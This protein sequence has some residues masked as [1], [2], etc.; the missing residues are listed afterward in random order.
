MMLYTGN[1][2]EQVIKGVTN[3]VISRSF[4]FSI[5]LVDMIAG[6]AQAV[7]DIRGTILFPLNPKGRNSLSIK[8]TTLAIYPE[9][10]SK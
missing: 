4:T 5:F 1:L 6:M 7:P 3:M 10:S 2:A 8:K 9:S